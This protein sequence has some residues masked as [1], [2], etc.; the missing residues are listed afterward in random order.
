MAE[1]DWLAAEFETKRA[2]LRAVA[3]Q[4]L[5]SAHQADDAVQESWLRLSRSGA[6]GVEN[7]GGWLTTV[8]ARVC[9]DM[10][11]SRKSRREEPMQVQES[12]ASIVREASD[13]P[14]HEAMLAD[15]VGSALLVVL[16]T[17]APSERLAFVLHDI[18]AVPFDE[19]GPIVGRSPTAARQ[20][21]S[22]G[23]RR[24]QG[25]SPDPDADPVRHREVVM[26]FLAASRGGDFDALLMLLD[27][28][29]I[30]RAEP[31]ATPPGVS[32]EVRTATG[33]AN[34]FV[35]RASAAQLA[36]VDGSPGAVWAPRGKPR[37]VFAFTI[38]SGK[39]VEIELIADRERI[40]LLN[41]VIEE[42]QVP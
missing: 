9:L 14:E 26:A 10:L 15:S 42:P 24:I 29:V 3:L 21:A 31:G 32:S 41:V 40:R 28:E 19:I 37:A 7:L 13:G 22:R 4:M 11:R 18:F 39:I 38:V 34:A 2:H 33:V 36:V 35:G 30:L 5:G 25:V 6:E 20:L 16:D 17:L 12:E 23:R 8:V 27:P 1:D